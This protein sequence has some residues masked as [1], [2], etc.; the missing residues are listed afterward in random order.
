[1]PFSRRRRHEISGDSCCV[2]RGGRRSGNPGALV[3]TDLGSWD[4]LHRWVNGKVLLEKYLY[5]GASGPA[6]VGQDR[7]RSELIKAGQGRVPAEL[8]ELAEQWTS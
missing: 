2:R 4:G 1:M 3:T 5:P 8:R 7:M 6:N